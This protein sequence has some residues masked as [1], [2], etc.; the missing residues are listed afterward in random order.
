MKEKLSTL[1]AYCGATSDSDRYITGL[2]TDSRSSADAAGALFFAIRTDV[3]DGHR[4]LPDLY[5][6][7]VRAFVVDHIPDIMQ[8][9]ADAD[10]IV[11][12]DVTRALKQIAQNIRRSFSI[13]VVGITGSRGK[14]IVKELLYRAL[15]NAGVK[16]TRSPRSWNSQLGVPLSVWLMEQDTEIAVFEAGI[17]RAGQ[18]ADIAAIINP[19]IGILTE[20]T[21]EHDGGFESRHQ[22][23]VEKARLFACCDTIICPETDS[24]ANSVIRDLYPAK[25]IITAGTGGSINQSLASMALQALGYSPSL[26]D[27]IK[28]VSTRLDVYEGVNDCLMI[29]DEFTNDLDSLG[30]ALDFMMRRT[31]SSRRNTLIAGDLVHSD[32]ADTDLLYRQL[33]DIAVSRGIDR[34]IAIGKEIS[35]HTDAFDAM[36]ATVYFADTADFISHFDPSRF[37]SE[38]ILIKGG[39]DEDFSGIRNLIE[40]PRHQTIFEI[41]LDS[42]VHNYN[43]FKSLVKPTTGIIAM[44]KASAYGTGSLEIAKTLQSQ[45]ASYLAVAV[46]EEGVALRRAGITMPIMVLNPMTTNYQALFNYRLEPAVFSLRELEILLDHAAARDIHAYPIHIKLD[47]GMHRV[48]FISAEIDALATAL[49]ATERVHAASVFSHLATADCLDEDI[50]TQSQ[51]DSFEEM[52]GRLGQL[53]KNSFKRHML[54]TAG[55][56]RFPKYQY[57]FVRLGIGL[58]GVS[59]LPPEETHIDLKAV[60]GLSSTI[61]S[62]KTWDADTTIGYSRRGRLDRQSVIATIP[63]GYADGIDRHFGCGNSSFVVNGCLCPTVGNICMDLCMIDVTGANA[64]IGDR[65]EI[66]GPDAPIEK[67]AEARGTIPY[68]ILTSVSPRVHRI[69]YRE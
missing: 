64:A 52:T 15:V 33:S 58:Y 4:Y 9:A 39:A 7:G 26:L 57:D 31:T 42:V 23:I 37:D 51:F 5:R 19:T 41:N 60:A 14:T 16:V 61:I 38:L 24:V 34:I 48:G 50:Y 59:P 54:N 66:F 11:V 8:H 13:P 1:A 30:R 55:I 47:T 56:M 45:G 32:N 35:R 65:V 21:G 17:D 20:I 28:E 36:I 67:L 27:G 12:D 44:V 10:F 63:I 6:R 3:N 43:S 2:L 53:L 40:S 62:L 25:N 29:Y 69:Y 22:K 18:M 46:V 49:N 68:E